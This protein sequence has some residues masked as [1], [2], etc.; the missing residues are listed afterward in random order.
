MKP[1]IAHSITAVPDAAA[2]RHPRY[3]YWVVVASH[4]LVD[5]FPMFIVS[6]VIVLQDRLALTRGQE[7]AVWVAT[8][9]FSGLIQPLMAWLGDRYNTRLAGPLGLAMGAV[10]IGSGS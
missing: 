6:L 10:C 4:A 2:V 5:V 8:P 7:T 9:I 1:G 3:D